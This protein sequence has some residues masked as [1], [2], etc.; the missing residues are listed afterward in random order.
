MFEM[1]SVPKIVCTSNLSNCIKFVPFYSQC[2]YIYILFV[3]SN[4]FKYRELKKK[5]RKDVFV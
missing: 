4:E 2:N 3:K 5:K 1:D